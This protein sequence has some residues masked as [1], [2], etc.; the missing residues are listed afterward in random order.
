MTDPK[1]D[2]DLWPCG[3]MVMDGAGHVQQINAT[4]RRWL[5]LSDAPAAPLR[6]VDLLSRAGRIYFE[7]HLRPLLATQGHFSEVSIEMERPDGSRFGVFL[8]GKACLVEG[9]MAEAHFCVF[10]NEQR[11][12]FERELVT[13]RRESDEFRSLVRSSP[14]AIVSVDFDLIIRAWNPAA[15]KLFGYS[16]AEAVGQRFDMLLIPS[17]ESAKFPQ[18]LLRLAAGEVLRS[19]TERRHKDGHLLPVERSIAAI[20]DK[21]QEYAGFV[22]VYSDISARKAADAQIKTL[23]HEINHRSKNL[24]TIVQVIARQTGRLYQGAEFISVFNKRLASL[25]A[26]QDILIKNRGENAELE[27]IVTTQFAHLIDPKTPQVRISG[28]KVVLNEKTS[29]AIGMAIFELATNAVKYGALSQDKGIVTLTWEVSGGQRPELTITWAEAGG[30]QV[31]APTRRGFGSQVTGP[32]LESYTSGKTTR[33]YAAGG[34]RWVFTAPL[35][36]LAQREENWTDAGLG[37]DTEAHR[38]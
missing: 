10:Q 25:A 3:L 13:K 9:A 27:R 16:E 12:R 11:Q 21:S 33:D 14:Q 36:P 30:P 2:P 37:E 19:E 6:F 24:L 22:A 17:E 8:N 1:I 7:T 20:S 29:Q 28:P 31:A 34:F 5:G 38:A 26:N 18:K 15:E 4:L 23:L 32:I 35:E